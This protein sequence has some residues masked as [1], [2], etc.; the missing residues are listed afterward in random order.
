[1]SLLD[2]NQQYFEEENQYSPLV[3]KFKKLPEFVSNLTESQL[4][5][6]PVKSKNLISFKVRLMR[7]YKTFILFFKVNIFSV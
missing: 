1:M 2:F 3:Q 4:L 7:V 5:E 6:F